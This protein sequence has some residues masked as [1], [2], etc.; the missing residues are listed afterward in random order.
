MKLRGTLILVAILALLGAYVYFFELRK[1]PAEK[2]SSTVIVLNI[3]AED[4][5]GIEVK[6]E[7][8]ESVIA[9]EPG[10]EWRVLK[11]EEKE[12]DQTRVNQVLKRLGPLK[13]TRVL[14]DSV[15]LAAFGLSEPRARITLKL[16][17]GSE[18]RLLVGE[19]NPA[20]TAY[21]VQ[22]EGQKEVY[23]AYVSPI[24]ELK[25]LVTEPPYKPTP[26]P[27]PTFTPTPVITVTIT[28]SPTPAGG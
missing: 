26:T 1:P 9:R 20:G 6:S 3:P 18:R 2:P 7:D 22:V 27:A 24:N 8:G 11:P 14:T 10:G 21:Y 23:L 25:R 28:P 17:D 13:A 5:T 15:D 4:V 12:A 19:K 16:R